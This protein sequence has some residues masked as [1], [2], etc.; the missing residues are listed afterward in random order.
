VCI[1]IRFN[2]LEKLKFNDKSVDAKTLHWTHTYN[3]P[4]RVKT[5]QRKEKKTPLDEPTVPS[6]HS[7]IVGTLRNRPNEVDTVG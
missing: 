1:R 6:V 5:E 2:I 3:T 7:V 4:S